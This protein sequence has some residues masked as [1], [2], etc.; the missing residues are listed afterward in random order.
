MVETH[1]SKEPHVKSL[2]MVLGLALIASSLGA[3]D[4]KP[5]KPRVDLPG[6][7]SV[8]ADPAPKRNPVGDKVSDYKPPVKVKIQQKEPPPPKK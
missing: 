4:K 5:A 6:D 3:E 8:K 7:G 2:T 1:F